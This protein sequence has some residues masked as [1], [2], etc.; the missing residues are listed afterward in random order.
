MGLESRDYDVHPLMERQILKNLVQFVQI[1]CTVQPKNLVLLQTIRNCPEPYQLSLA[2][3]PL[4]C[5]LDLL[6]RKCDTQRRHS[7]GPLQLELNQEFHASP[8]SLSQNGLL[9]CPEERGHHHSQAQLRKPRTNVSALWSPYSSHERLP[10]TFHLGWFPQT[11]HLKLADAPV[12]IPGGN[13][14]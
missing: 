2:N 5:E 6:L 9:R 3:Q 12:P 8:R 10:L 1:L 4:C 14:T 11:S 7:V 13:R